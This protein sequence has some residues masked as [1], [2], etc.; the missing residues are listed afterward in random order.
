MVVNFPLDLSLLKRLWLFLF[1]FQ[2]SY[3]TGVKINAPNTDSIKNR[4]PRVM[5]GMMTISSKS[6][7]SSSSTLSSMSSLSSLSSSNNNN[8]NSNSSH[9]SSSSNNN[10]NN[11]SREKQTKLT[12]ISLTNTRPIYS[13]VSKYANLA[14]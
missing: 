4:T 9:D 13:T 7:S 14:L 3:V 1:Y 12:V 2:G 8:I 6:S 10:N 11:D 5:K